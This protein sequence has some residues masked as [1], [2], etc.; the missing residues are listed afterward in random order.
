MKVLSRLMCLAGLHN[1]IE[2]DLDFFN[3]RNVTE[4][5]IACK[6]KR[7]RFDKREYRRS[8]WNTRW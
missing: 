7:K 4:Y 5:C 1:W 8:F 6:T 2:C 3:P